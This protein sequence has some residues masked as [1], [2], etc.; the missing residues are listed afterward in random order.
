MLAKLDNTLYSVFPVIWDKLEALLHVC[1]TFL[2]D[3]KGHKSKPESFAS[4][5]NVKMVLFYINSGG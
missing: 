2:R 4:Q 3:G 1:G 5:C